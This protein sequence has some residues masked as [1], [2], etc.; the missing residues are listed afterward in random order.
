M[1]TDTTPHDSWIPPLWTELTNRRLPDQGS[2]KEFPEVELTCPLDLKPR[3]EEVESKLPQGT[4]SDQ[5][6]FGRELEAAPDQDVPAGSPPKLKKL[7]HPHS[8]FRHV[9][10][11]VIE[12]TDVTDVDREAFA[13]ASKTIKKLRIR[14]TRDPELGRALNEVEA[15]L[16]RLSDLLSPLPMQRLALV[17]EW[18]LCQVTTLLGE[19]NLALDQNTPTKYND[20][21]DAY[22]RLLDDLDDREPRDPKVGDRGYGRAVQWASVKPAI[23]DGRIF[24]AEVRVKWNPHIS[25]SGIPI[26]HG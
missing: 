3:F 26:Q 20:A 5:V 12:P 8:D 21:R 10:P 13:T 23:R 18:I 16:K 9:D 6:K 7:P 14:E 24:G 15:P 25:S 1:A 19:I 4:S 11:G 17:F 2:K 22:I